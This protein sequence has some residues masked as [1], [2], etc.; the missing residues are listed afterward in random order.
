RNVLPRLLARVPESLTC[1]CVELVEP[2]GLFLP[3]GD[4]RGVYHPRGH[5][6]WASSARRS[7]SSRRK[8]NSPP[9][10]AYFPSASSTTAPGSPGPPSAG[11]ATRDHLCLAKA[12]DQGGGRSRRPDAADRDTAVIELAA[13]ALVSSGV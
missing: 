4:S 1:E 7:S 2:T 5:K 11:P 10:P 12:A 6:S 9:M 3:H 8:F 13:P